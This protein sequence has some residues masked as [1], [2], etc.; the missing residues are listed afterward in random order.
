MHEASISSTSWIRQ[1]GIRR[2]QC[3]AANEQSHIISADCCKRRA[4]KIT[5]GISRLC[6]SHRKPF[7]VLHDGL[8]ASVICCACYRLDV[9][10]YKI[11]QWIR[12]PTVQGRLAVRQLQFAVPAFHHFKSAICK[13]SWQYIM[14]ETS[15]CTE[16]SYCATLDNRV[17]RSG[18]WDSAPCDKLGSN[19]MY[20]VT[21]RKSRYAIYPDCMLE[22]GI[23]AGIKYLWYHRACSARGEQLGGSNLLLAW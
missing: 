11:W 22:Q 8:C 6:N 15:F 17:S 18:A 2:K 23:I 10:N 5:G 20:S 7:L 19:S 16:S 21:P 12:D 3:K 9:M 4:F 14:S 1:K 13:R